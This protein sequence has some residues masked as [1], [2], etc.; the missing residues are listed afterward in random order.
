MDGKYVFGVFGIYFCVCL[1]SFCRF[2]WTLATEKKIDL[3]IGPI[4][5]APHSTI[6]RPSHTTH[7]PKARTAFS[8]YRGDSRS[9]FGKVGG[10]SGRTGLLRVQVLF[11][12]RSE[13]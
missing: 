4:T 10:A 3:M 6:L 1:A 11:R 2:G 8:R 12:S 7:H 13:K 9:G 5:H